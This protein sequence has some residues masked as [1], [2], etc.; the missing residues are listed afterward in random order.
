MP[1]GYED[2]RKH[3]GTHINLGKARRPK[4]AAGITAQ[5]TALEDP[6]PRSFDRPLQSIDCRSG[7]GHHMLYAGKAA[8]WPQHSAHFGQDLA[9]TV[10]RAKNKGAEQKLY[11]SRGQ[12]E[13]LSSEAAKIQF[14]GKLLGAATQDVV[15]LDVG[16][17]GYQP[18]P[19][20]QVAQIGPGAWP[21]FDNNRR[22][23]RQQSGF[24]A[25]V[26]P[27]HVAIEGREKPGVQTTAD[28]IVDHAT[29]P[30][31]VYA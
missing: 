7:G 21:K 29:T 31:E 3:E 5:V 20:T 22:C 25:G 13:L 11:R 17:Y 24:D 27:M 23:V 26:L 9:R 2:C 6:L 18:S 28:R 15:H 19:G 10:H 30:C 1:N 8:A 14:D 4:S 12:I 16:F